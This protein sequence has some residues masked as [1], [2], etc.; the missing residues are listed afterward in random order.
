MHYILSETI[1]KTMPDM[2][3]ER[4]NEKTRHII[5]KIPELKRV[6]KTDAESIFL[7]DP[8]AGS[9]SEVVMCYPGFYATFCYRIAHEI[10]LAEIP[11]LARFICEYAHSL[12]GIDIHP[13]AQIGERF[14]IDHGTGIV[15]GETAV[16]GNGVCIYQGVT[17]GAKSFPKNSDGSFNKSMKR[18]PTVMDDCVIYACATILGADTV[19]GRGSVIGANV[20]IAS[21][22]PEGSTVCY[23][24]KGQRQWKEK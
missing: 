12:T 7:H 10:Y 19:I 24:K 13:G 1:T 8:A 11:L 2:D 14:S 4:V 17:I 6:L 3:R 5:S 15:I 18:H 16:I 21:S 22:V 20:R 9:I 23:E